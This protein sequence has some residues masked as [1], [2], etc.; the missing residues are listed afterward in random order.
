MSLCL[1]MSANDGDF[2]VHEPRED[3]KG[4]LFLRARRAKTIAGGRQSESNKLPAARLP[5]NAP[6]KS[7]Y[8]IMP[9]RRAEPSAP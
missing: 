6:G 9:G 4:K 3:G 7:R 8:E 2:R 1:S 5:G